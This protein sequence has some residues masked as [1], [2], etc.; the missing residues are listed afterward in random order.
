MSFPGGPPSFP[1]AARVALA[2]TQLR[3]NLGHA[4]RTIRAKRAT[5]VAEVPDWQELREAGRAI[6]ERVLRHL[7]EYLVA[8][9]AG[10]TRAGGTV[11]WARDGPEC[12]RIVGD[13]V[14]AHGATE[15]VKS[16]S[17]TTEE[18][19]LNE[20]LAEVVSGRSRP[21]SPS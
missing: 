1:D 5:A 8:L 4:T 16:K 7:D 17:L 12:N 15:V 20:A 14:A 2:D 19:G 10:V 18:T 9:E 3:H 21:I 6:K 13:L 11:H